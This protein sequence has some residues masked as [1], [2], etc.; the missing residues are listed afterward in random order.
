MK[1]RITKIVPMFKRPQPRTREKSQLRI[2]TIITDQGDTIEIP[3]LYCTNTEVGE[4]V[5]QYAGKAVDIRSDRE[6]FD[7]TCVDGVWE[8]SASVESDQDIRRGGRRRR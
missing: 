8:C 2:L 4:G 1:K 5:R 7:L 3:L 6:V